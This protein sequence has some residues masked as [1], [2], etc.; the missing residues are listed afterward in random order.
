MHVSERSARRV[1][2]ALADLTG[3]YGE[4]LVIE[5]TW[6]VAREHYEFV[7]ERFRAGTVGAAGT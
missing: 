2:D 1:T 3:E 7:L 5:D 6:R 4:G